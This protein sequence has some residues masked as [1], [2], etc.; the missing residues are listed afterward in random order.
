MEDEEEKDEVGIGGEGWGGKEGDDV[1]K[2]EQDTG[3]SSK[4]EWVRAARCWNAMQR[5]NMDA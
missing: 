5:V 3:W 1:I 4:K 2:V